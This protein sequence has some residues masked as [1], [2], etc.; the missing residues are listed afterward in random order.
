[1]SLT[2]FTYLQKRRILILTIILTISSVL[3]SLTAS[4]FLGFYNTFNAYLGEGEDILAI[5]DRK[6]TT[7]F[8][9]LVPLQLTTRI[10]SI[11][12]VLATSPEIITPTLVKGKSIFIRG[13]IPE[14]LAKLNSLTIL[15]GETLELNNT[16]S[17][18]L[19]KTLAHTL[20]LTP[21][22]TMLVSGVLANRYVELTI[23]GIYESNSP[24]DDEALTPLY[25]GQWL[26]GRNYGLVTI[27]RVKIDRSKV[28]P[29]QIFEVIAEE[30]STPQPGE[31]RKPS[32]IEEIIPIS[33][34]TIN[35]ENL[36]VK[37]TSEFMKTYLDRYGMTQETLLI[38]STVVFFFASATMFGASHTIIRQHEREIFVLRSLGTSAKT[39]KLDL[40][41]KLLPWSLSASALGILISTALLFALEQSSALQALSHTIHFRPDP[42]LI[43]VNLLL[44]SALVVTGVIHSSRHLNI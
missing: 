11:D 35:P 44:V 1:M 33:T 15:D 23:K 26:R 27:I 17:A 9:G 43:A 16:N 25:I 10:E 34:A 8:T 38:L 4:S 19:G 37:E 30:P 42:L 20:G 12:G 41:V 29:A 21:G 3:F 6:S 2:G 24:L 7:P 22:D 28:V 18:I 32:P 40:I 36:G 14:E 39:L 13:V 31:E 5:Y